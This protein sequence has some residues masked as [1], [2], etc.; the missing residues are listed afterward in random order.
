MKKFAWLAI[1]IAMMSLAVASREIPVDTAIKG[2][3]RTISYQYGKEQ[4]VTNKENEM[5][6]K[7]FTGSRWSSN[8]FD[9]KTKQ[10]GGIGGGAYT[11]NG[12]QYQE[13]VEYYSWDSSVCGKKFTF[14]MTIENGMLHQSGFMEWKGDPKYLIDEWYV[15]V[16]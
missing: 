8:S 3:W 16:D 6:Y 2:T 7:M 15:R 10:I 14:T 12:D 5:T 1:T 4:K 9:K 13:T 11:I